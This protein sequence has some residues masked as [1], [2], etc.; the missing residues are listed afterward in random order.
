MEIVN[1]SNF[2]GK[3][4]CGGGVSTSFR[5]PPTIKE[6]DS[7]EACVTLH[8]DFVEMSYE[9][10]IKFSSFTFGWFLKLVDTPRI[11]NITMLWQWTTD[12]NK[13]KF[14]TPCEIQV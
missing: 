1:K 7:S 11:C 13:T 8:C 10:N 9:L 2:D 6:P 12:N 14:V 4:L 5:N 3:K